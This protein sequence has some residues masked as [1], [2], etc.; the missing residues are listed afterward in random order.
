MNSEAINIA[1]HSVIEPTALHI[2]RREKSDCIIAVVRS[3]SARGTSTM[4][5]L[6]LLVFMVSVSFCCA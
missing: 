5:L 1:T 2:C 6:T 4:P 3:R